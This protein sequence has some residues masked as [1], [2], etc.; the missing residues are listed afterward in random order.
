MK[1][2]LVVVACAACASAKK[3]EPDLRASHEVVSG[4]GRVS[5]GGMHMDVS[6][7]HTFAQRT[8]KTTG[9]TLHSAS[10]VIP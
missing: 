4:A 8:T 10:P 5:G 1:I 9:S 3:S 2:L 6:I 7:G